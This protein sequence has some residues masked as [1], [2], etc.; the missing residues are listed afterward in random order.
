MCS[1]LNSDFATNWKAHVFFIVDLIYPLPFC[2]HPSRRCQSLNIL[3]VSRDVRVIR[4]SL[5]RG[6][7]TNHKQPLPRLL[8]YTRWAYSTQRES[9]RHCLT[10]VKE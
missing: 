3:R 4:V 7:P 10:F 2:G 1:I 6:W 5:S 9:Y 8:K